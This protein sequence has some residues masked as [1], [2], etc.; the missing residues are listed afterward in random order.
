VEAEFVSI[1]RWN[2]SLRIE[3]NMMSRGIT[4]LITVGANMGIRNFNLQKSQVRKWGSIVLNQFLIYTNPLYPSLNQFFL[5]ASLHHSSQQKEL[6]FGSTI[7]GGTFSLPL[8][9]PQIKPL[10][11]G[12]SKQVLPFSSII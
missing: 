11:I 7:F 1:F 6:V 10:Q 9:P 3:S 5:F 12:T 2:G 4:W 8:A